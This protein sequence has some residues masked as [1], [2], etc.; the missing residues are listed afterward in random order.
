MLVT[1]TAIFLAICFVTLG[2]LV[3]YINGVAVES[4]G[5]AFAD[6]LISLF[7]STIGEWIYPVIALSAI[8]VMF[9]TSADSGGFTAP[10]FS[11]C[12]G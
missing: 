3:M 6:Q 7:T 2:T 9:S 4:G 5:A 11:G 10:I 12:A 8:T 1:A